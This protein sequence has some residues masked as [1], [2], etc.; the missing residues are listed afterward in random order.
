[1]IFTG[2]S[3]I[4]WLGALLLS[5]MLALSC[6]LVATMGTALTKNTIRL[7][8]AWYFVALMLMMAL[9]RQ[10]RNATTRRGKIARWCWTWGVV[11]FVLHLVM[12]FHFFHHWSHAHAYEHTRDVSGIGEGIYVSYLFTGLW[13]MDTIW[14]WRWPQEFATRSIW[15][16]RC[17]HSFMLFIVFNGTIV[18]EAGMTRWFGVTMFSILGVAWAR[19]LP[20]S[21]RGERLL[22]Q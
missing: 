17:L 18:F 13:I 2:E 21:M 3:R 22:A 19:A 12:A 1:M 4:A 14:W 10:E 7:S 6:T 15:W 9:P 11:C 20:R 16:D 5:L 8:I